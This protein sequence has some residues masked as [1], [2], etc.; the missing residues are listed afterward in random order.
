MMVGVGFFFVA[1]FG[2]V[3]GLVRVAS[4]PAM[5]ATT[6]MAGHHGKKGDKNE[7]EEPVFSQESHGLPLI[8]S[9]QLNVAQRGISNGKTGI[10]QEDR[11][12]TRERA[13][14]SHL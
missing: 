9:T 13:K 14:E 7:N 6:A 11:N 10:Q 12:G 3:I 5:H 1:R 2:L 8:R 4:M